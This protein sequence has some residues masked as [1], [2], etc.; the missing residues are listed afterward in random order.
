MA[1]PTVSDFRTII[2]LTKYSDDK[3]TFWLG[4]ADAFFDQGR[5]DDLLDVGVC[6]WVAHNLVLNDA[7]AAQN[8][9]DDGSTKKVGD[10]SKTRDAELM[11]RQAE[12]PYYRTTYG[13][14]YIYYQSYVGA[15]GI[16]V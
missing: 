14:Q 6:N 4:K 16:S 10:I 13:Q 3:V 9:T 11:K 2:G 8:L 7:N 12:N 5:W 1:M 15:G